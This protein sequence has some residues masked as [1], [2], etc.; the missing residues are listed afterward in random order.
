MPRLLSRPVLT[1][2]ALF[3]SAPE[4]DSDIDSL[5]DFVIEPTTTRVPPP[6][7]PA[8][9]TC[10]CGRTTR[11]DDGDDPLYCSEVCARVDA[12]HALTA[13]SRSNSLAPTPVTTAPPTPL[14]GHM[15]LRESI[16][17]IFAPDL[18]TPPYVPTPLSASSSLTSF[19]GAALP[20]EMSSHYRRVYAK[21]E[22]ME[23]ERS[24]SHSRTH[25]KARPSLAELEEECDVET[26]VEREPGS[27]GEDHVP[28]PAAVFVFVAVDVQVEHTERDDHDHHEHDADD[29]PDAMPPALG[30]AP[31]V[32]W[33]HPFADPTPA[34]TH[35]DASGLEREA[36]LLSIT[37]SELSPFVAYAPVA[38]PPVGLRTRKSS[39]CFAGVGPAGRVEPMARPRAQSDTKS[40]LPSAAFAEKPLPPTPG[41]GDAVPLALE[42]PVEVLEP[43]TESPLEPAELLERIPAEPC[44]R[45]EN[46]LPLSTLDL[47]SPMPSSLESSE[48][49]TPTS[50]TAP[51]SPR[52]PSARIH[53]AE[54]DP[55][56][57]PSRL[58]SL[59]AYP[60][61]TPKRSP[62]VSTL[63]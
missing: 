33:H 3:D 35:H 45:V 58:S 8:P 52:T 40:H 39:V 46:D 57:T 25:S 17:G 51:P 24:R 22:R 59:D 6:P 15:L 23:R 14:G 44:F 19:D 36:D 42:A 4:Y 55:Q 61:A 50:G 26:H 7:S 49:T 20:I 56:V 13:R 32:V 31:G 27:D 5:A 2:P 28:S 16:A 48:P 12:F 43:P 30:P 10:L 18:S 47:S 21:R 1:S 63:R 29:T 41:H 62:V 60:D 34:L 53:Q 9:N 38:P 37:D 54:V 11:D